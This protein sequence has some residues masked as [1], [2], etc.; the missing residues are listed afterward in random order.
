[1]SYYEFHVYDNYRFAKLHD[2]IIDKRI[3]LQN[4]ANWHEEIEL[5]Y[6]TEGTGRAVIDSEHVPMK[7][8]TITVINSN[9]I[10]YIAPDS[11]IL[12]F[13]I[14][15]IDSKFLNSAGL[16]IKKIDFEK[17]IS[18]DKAI[19]FYEMII[20]ENAAA[21]PFSTVCT[22]G[23]ALSLMAHISANYSFERKI[24]Q[25]EDKIKKAIDFIRTNFNEN[26]T[27]DMVADY[28]GFSKY[29]FSHKFKEISGY[30]VKEYIQMFRCY[31]AHAMLATHKYTV[32][33]V[34]AECGFS[35]SSY[36]TKVYRKFFPATPSQ[37][38]KK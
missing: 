5:L 14:L 25:S 33:E 7:K 16:D 26:L 11:E 6:C 36:F 12:R 3:E 13:Y 8:G 10:H 29:Y 21:S 28:V 37:I 1:M 38:K 34:A 18:D 15:I 4:Q 32:T 35:D 23:L 31:E 27:V 19:S 30:S 24:I 20:K 2:E 9:K 17:S 22:N